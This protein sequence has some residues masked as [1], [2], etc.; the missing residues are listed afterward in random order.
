MRPPHIC[1]TA[2][3]REGDRRNR[4]GEIFQTGDQIGKSLINLLND[5]ALGVFGHGLHGLIY[6]FIGAAIG[7][8]QHRSKLRP[9]KL[10]PL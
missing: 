6:G 1:S 5:L 3:L 9:P 4:R 7:F 10:K 8:F 2:A